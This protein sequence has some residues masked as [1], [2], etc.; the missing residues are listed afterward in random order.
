MNT[1]ILNICMI[2]ALTACV[3]MLYKEITNLEKDVFEL[4]KHSGIYMIPSYETQSIE[5]K[6]EKHFMDNILQGL[7]E[8]RSSVKI[9]DVEDIEHETVKPDDDNVEN[10]D[11]ES[12][13][14]TDSTK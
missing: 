8:K 12:C 10:V 5:A 6:E 11:K 13:L 1:E 9:E 7:E 4:K 3:Y 2:I 14:D